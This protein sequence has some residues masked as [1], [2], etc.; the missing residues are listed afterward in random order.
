MLIATISRARV[1]AR[2]AAATA[3]AML[4]ATAPAATAADFPSHAVSLIVPYAPGATT[5]QIARA[6]A[7]HMSRDLGQPVVVEN[8]TGAN[9]IIAATH[10]AQARPDGYTLM[11]SSDSTAV[12][13]PLLYKKLAYDPDR[14]LTP[15]GLLT[16]LPLL[17]TV[18]PKLPVK[19]LQEFIAYAKAHPGAVNFSSTGNGGTFHLAG[20]L[21]S[22]AAGIELT[23][24]PYKGGAPALNALIANEVQALFGVVGSALPHVKAGRVRALAV[25]SPQRL[26]L[27]PDV[28]TFAESGFEKYIVLVRYGLMAPAGTPADRIA[29]LVDSVNKA[30]A[31]PKLRKTFGDLG[32][33]L[34]EQT[35]PE[36]YAS[37]IKSDRVLW[38]DLVKRQNIS[39][40]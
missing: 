6:V 39:L 26:D 12:L 31:D 22:Q 7:D 33:I 2:L 28:P 35:S 24:V 15:V 9:G 38:A 25:A 1:F 8:R 13:N 29:R 21:F 18:N 10:T 11:L 37:L 5:D 27:L 30:L 17:M 3:A 4:Y 40:D 20:E 16:D 36:H 32:F 34:P 19:T 14:D 23:H